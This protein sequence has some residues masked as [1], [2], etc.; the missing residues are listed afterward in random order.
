MNI[1]YDK[2]HLGARLK[3]NSFRKGSDERRQQRPRHSHKTPKPS[4]DYYDDYYYDHA[5]WPQKR[6]GYGE[7]DV[8]PYKL[9]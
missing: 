3:V 5:P 2:C 1:I 6:Q 8:T 4:P 9:V 7:D